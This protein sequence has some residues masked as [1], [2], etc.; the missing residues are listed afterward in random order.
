MAQRTE[1]SS[2][3]STHYRDNSVLYEYPNPVCPNA[4][5]HFKTIL[6]RR[7]PTRTGEIFGGNGLSVPHAKLAALYTAK[8]DTRRAKRWTTIAED[9]IPSAIIL[10]KNPELR[11][12]D[13]AMGETNGLTLP[14]LFNL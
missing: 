8:V 10:V 3:L 14:H 6:Q 12:P 9:S 4:E 1:L 2:F 13:S 5:R 7:S 11:V